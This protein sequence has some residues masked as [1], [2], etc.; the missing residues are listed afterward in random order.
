MAERKFRD[1]MIAAKKLI[2]QGEKCLRDAAEHIAKASE[3]GASQR[4]IAEEIGK[5]QAWVS[6]FLAWRAGGYAEDTPFGPESKAKRERQKDRDQAPDQADGEDLDLDDEKDDDQDEDLDDDDHGQ[7]HP[8]QEEQVVEA[9]GEADNEGVFGST[10]EGSER[11]QPAPGR[12]PEDK[13]VLLIKML[14]M[15]GS[16][17]HGERA[18]AALMVERL[19]AEIG[20]TWDELI[21]EDVLAQGGDR[22]GVYVH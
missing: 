5:S 2:V 10:N 15:L 12:T 17:Q 1:L 6:R 19:R 11:A 3:Q 21:V 4:A 16:H 22:P 20:L 7:H 13:R 14:G 18:N 9:A 8:D